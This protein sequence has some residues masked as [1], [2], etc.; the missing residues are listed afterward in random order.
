MEDIKKVE[1]TKGTLVK[2][3][4]IIAGSILIA[5]VLIKTNS[6]DKLLYPMRQWG[7]LGSFISGIFFTS[8][9]TT[10]PAIVALIEISHHQNIFIV[11]MFGGLGASFGDFILFKFMRDSLSQHVVELYKHRKVG[12]RIIKLLKLKYFRWIT[13]LIGGMIIASPFPDEIG[14]SMLGFTK[15]KTR[16]FLPVAFFLNFLGL[17]VITYTVKFF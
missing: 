15:M 3:L 16:V 14:I 9:F 5:V 1:M 13:F 4:L 8:I 17:L 2:D 10:A 6:I 7:F 11:S 12:E